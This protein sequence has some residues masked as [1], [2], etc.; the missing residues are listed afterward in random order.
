MENVNQ[1]I[2]MNG[3]LAVYSADTS[4]TKSLGDSTS[5]VHQPLH[6]PA[7]RLV[8][9]ESGRQPGW[10]GYPQPQVYTDVSFRP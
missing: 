6:I 1:R 4:P 5:P 2:R 8:A 9:H 10:P 3:G 7:K